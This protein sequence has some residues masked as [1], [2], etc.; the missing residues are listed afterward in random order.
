MDSLDLKAAARPKDANKVEEVES[1]VD[2]L[3]E[4]TGGLNKLDVK[5]DDAIACVLCD[6]KAEPKSSYCK[7]CELEMEKFGDL[8]WSTKIRETMRIL[9]EIRL[10]K[11]DRKTIV[12]SQVRD[13]L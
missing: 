11:V 2:E 5:A 3:E 1:E 7:S 12:F 13:Y 8:K 4:L 6:L 9:G 10:E